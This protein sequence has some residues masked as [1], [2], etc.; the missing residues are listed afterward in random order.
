M[1]TAD[2]MNDIKNSGLAP[3]DPLEAAMM[4]TLPPGNYT[5]VVRDVNGTGIGLVEVYAL[6]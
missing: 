1:V 5:A 2:Q 6:Q 3:T 4:V